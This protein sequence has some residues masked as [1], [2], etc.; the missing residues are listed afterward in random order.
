MEEQ[1]R[2][3]SGRYRLTGRIGSGAMG[4]VWLGHDERLNRTVAVKE[5]L[6][7]YGLSEAD[8][9]DAKRRAMREGRLAARLQHPHAIPVFDVVEDGGRPVLVMEY[10]ASESLSA[11][12]AARGPLPPEEV[13]RIGTQIA[14]ALAAAHAVGIVHRDVKPGNVLLGERVAKITD[15]GISRG[16]GEAT[17]TATGMLAGTPAYL[18]PEVARGQPADFRSDVFSF[19]STLYTAVEGVPPFGRGDNPMA[20]MHRVANGEI[21]PPENAGPLGPLLVR[22]MEV[23]PARRPTMVEAARMLATLSGTPTPVPPLEPVTVRIE[24]PPPPPPTPP[25]APAEP[26]SFAPVSVPVPM[27]PRPDRGGRRRVLLLLLAAAALL[28]VGTVGVIALLDRDPGGLA[29]PG[30]TSSR[31][32]APPTK[33][34]PPT[35]SPPPTSAPATD[36]AQGLTDYYALL[37]DDLEAG[38]DRLTDRFKRTRSPSFRGYSNFFGE[39]RAVSTSNVRLRE[40]G[41][42]SARVTYTYRSGR[43][44][45]ERHIYTLVLQGD[46]WLIDGQRSGS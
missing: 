7:P 13:A 41:T 26:T 44:V 42:V 6:L 5:L 24:Q 46:R 22:L 19:G 11:A 39:F 1:D 3:I 9:G 20:L 31:Q 25:P 33:S 35:N 36:A 15:F 16:S 28:G 8:A 32:P 34:A 12:V 38:Y 21:R 37:P 27:A 18:A 40:D 30:P 2:T 23:D 4:V 10:L 29:G 45:N 14:S 43:K 17:V